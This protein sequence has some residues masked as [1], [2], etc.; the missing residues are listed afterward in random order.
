M[1]VSGLIQFSSAF[2]Q[3]T[4]KPLHGHSKI[5]YEVDKDDNSDEEVEEKVVPKP[6]T[7]FDKFLNTN[8][9]SPI[10]QRSKVSLFEFGRSNT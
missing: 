8:D 9:T 1:A 6:R 10:K 7:K 2:S 5:V 3:K 4:W